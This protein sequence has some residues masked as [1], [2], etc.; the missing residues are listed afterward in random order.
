LGFVT[1]LKKIVVLAAYGWPA[2]CVKGE[3]AG[4]AVTCPSNASTPNAGGVAE[5]VVGSTVLADA[6]PPPETSNVLVSVPDALG[7][8]STMSWSV[9][10]V[11]GTSGLVQLQV[12]DDAGKLVP[13]QSQ[14]PT[15][16]DAVRPDGNVA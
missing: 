7:A 5:I 2:A 1:V 15:A 14:P 4:S 3:P 16:D 12:T 13:E 6:A 8:A 10:L 9:L 11:G